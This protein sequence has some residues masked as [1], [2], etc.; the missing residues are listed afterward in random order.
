MKRNVFALLLFFLSISFTYAKSPRIDSVAVY[1]LSE[2]SNRLLSVQS[3]QF[4]A[5]IVYDVWADDLGM[6]AHSSWEKVYMKFTDKMFIST[7]GDKGHRNLWYNGKNLNYYSFLNHQYATT[8]AP[9]TILQTMDT[10]SKSIGIEFP[11][12]DFFYPSFVEDILT[13]GSNL[14]YLGITKVGSQDCFHIAGKSE[15]ASFQFWIANDESLLPVKM[16]IIYTSEKNQPRYEAIYSN[17]ELNHDYSDAMFEFAVP[18]TATKVKFDL[19][20]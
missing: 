15:T 6:V 5:N 14:I 2:S 4:N 10:I 7:I 16:S 17:W 3:C 13:T 1:L 20:K 11:A 18:P 12:A 9:K 19:K 8:P